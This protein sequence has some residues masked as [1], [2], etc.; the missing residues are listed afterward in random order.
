[1]RRA[2]GCPAPGSCYVARDKNLL[3]LPVRLLKVGCNRVPARVQVIVQDAP[4]L[5]F[6][7]VKTGGGGKVQVFL[8]KFEQGIICRVEF[9]ESDEQVCRFDGF[10]VVQFNQLCRFGTCPA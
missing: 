6:V 5:V 9:V 4:Q 7:Q 2:A 10:A 3:V 8:G 1:M